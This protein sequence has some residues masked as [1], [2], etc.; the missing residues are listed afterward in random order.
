MNKLK[1]LYDGKPWVMYV[2]LL[3]ILAGAAVQVLVDL[4]NFA[5]VLL[6]IVLFLAFLVLGA[7]LLMKE[8]RSL[9]K[10]DSMNLAKVKAKVK[11]GKSVEDV[12]TITYAAVVVL[13][14]FVDSLLVMG[15]GLVLFLMHIVLSTV[16]V[17]YYMKMK[18]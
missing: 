8:A 4:P 5:K 15:I 14:T 16:L 1:Q 2:A 13:G 10:I 7:C 18:K 9:D 3:V 6:A 17:R 11:A 12:M